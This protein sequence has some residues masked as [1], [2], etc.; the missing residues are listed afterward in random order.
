MKLK[1]KKKELPKYCLSID[2]RNRNMKKSK[3]KYKTFPVT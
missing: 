1:F 3:P 2:L